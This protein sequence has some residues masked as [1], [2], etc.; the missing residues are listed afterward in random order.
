MFSEITGRKFAT[1]TK[2]TMKLIGNVVLKFIKWLASID[3]SFI[4]VFQAVLHL[5]KLRNGTISTLDKSTDE[6]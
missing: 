1:R 4:S 5:M 3:I 6:V 2:I